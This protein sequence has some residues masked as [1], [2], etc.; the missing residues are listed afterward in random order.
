MGE[1]KEKIKEIIAEL[2]SKMEIFGEVNI[3]ETTDNVQFQIKAHEA[4]LL[5]GEKG[6]N[7]V[8]LNH[9]I[10]RMV[11]A[12]IGKIEVPYS[13]DVN[14]YQKQKAEEIKDLARLSAQRV[15]YFKK[16]IQ[17]RPMS[18]YERRIVHAILTEYPDIITQSVGEEPNRKVV[19]K[20]FLPES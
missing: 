6:E 4:G 10:K 9:L 7:L 18:S 5:I 1:E 19:I 8:S 2:L 20:P 15:R 14:D 11:E 16:E 12:K 3:F 13:I 17:L